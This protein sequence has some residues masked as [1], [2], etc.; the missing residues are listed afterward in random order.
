[1]D[2]L[3]DQSDRWNLAA[4]PVEVMTVDNQ[5]IYFIYLHSWNAMRNAPHGSR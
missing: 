5:Q 4:R 3:I 1:M 2:T